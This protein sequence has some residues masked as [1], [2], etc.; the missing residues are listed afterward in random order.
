MLV[1]NR[2]YKYTIVFTKIKM[3]FTNKILICYEIYKRIIQLKINY[4]IGKHRQTTVWYT[5]NGIKYY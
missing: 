2:N 5:Q 1:Y 4:L 3:D